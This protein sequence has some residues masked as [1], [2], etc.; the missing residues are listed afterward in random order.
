MELSSFSHSLFSCNFLL[1]IL[2]DGFIGYFNLP[3]ALGVAWGRQGV[4]DFVGSI[5]VFDVVIS[6]LLA[7]V[8]DQGVGYAE[9]NDDLVPNKLPYIIL[10]DL[11]SEDC[12][13][14]FGEGVYGDYCKLILFFSEFE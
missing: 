6:K 13:D 12:F 8:G 10:C 5:S 1:D 14:P 2:E 3:I 9:S 4:L 11:M 7:I